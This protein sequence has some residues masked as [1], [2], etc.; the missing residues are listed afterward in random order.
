MV[1]LEIDKIIPEF[2]DSDSLFGEEL[3]SMKFGKPISEE[4][5]VEIAIKR[6]QFKD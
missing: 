1:H 5:M 6:T 3:R 4:L 2:I